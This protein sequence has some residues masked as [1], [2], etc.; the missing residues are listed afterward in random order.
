M[1]PNGIFVSR[2]EHNNVHQEL[3]KSTQDH[4]ERLREAE[5]SLSD[6]PLM[7]KLVYGCVGTVLTIVLTAIVYLVVQ[8]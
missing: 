2:E 8:R 5:K 4:E 6:V 1:N 7:R 3:S